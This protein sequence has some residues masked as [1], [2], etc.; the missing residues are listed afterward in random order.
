MSTS[1]S[2]AYDSSPLQDFCVA[3]KNSQLFINGLVC[4]NPKLVS[5]DD[6]SFSGLDI[7]GDT[8]NRLGSKGLIHFELNIGETMAVGIAALGSQNPGFNSVAD[9]VFGSN[10][11]ILDDVLAKAFQLDK[12]VVDWLQSQF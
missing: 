5:A 10:P 1:N 2:M 8:T 9:A 3:D 6:F 4:K 12:Q 7:A 11:E